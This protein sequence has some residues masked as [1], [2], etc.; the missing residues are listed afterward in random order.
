MNFFTLREKGKE[1]KVTKR[2]KEAEKI[3]PHKEEKKNASQRSATM[4]RSCIQYLYYYGS[5][6]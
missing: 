1:E 5:V 6:V 4:A 3:F 2:I